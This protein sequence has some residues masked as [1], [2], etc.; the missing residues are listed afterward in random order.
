MNRNRKIVVVSALSI[1][2][3]GL[4]AGWLAGDGW[5]PEPYQVSSM[6]GVWTVL[7]GNTIITVSPEDPKSGTG[8]VYSTHINAD[9]TAGGAVPDATA[10]APCIFKYVRTGPNSWRGKGV[11]YFTKD[12]KPQPTVLFLAVIDATITMTAPDKVEWARTN[13]SYLGSQDKDLDGLPDE[14]EKPTAVWESPLM[15]MKSL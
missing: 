10:E 3:L 1:V 7:G 12:T 5:P 4:T 2:A 6:A 15:V 8:F 9:P 11:T 14:G 13:S